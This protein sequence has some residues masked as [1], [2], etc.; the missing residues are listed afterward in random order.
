MCGSGYLGAK[1]NVAEE[2]VVIID[3]DDDVR[4]KFF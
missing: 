1:T 3:R 2:S 4:L